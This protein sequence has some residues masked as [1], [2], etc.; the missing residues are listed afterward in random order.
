MTAGAEPGIRPYK[1]K[2]AGK[3]CSTSPTHHK[4]SENTPSLV[5][6]LC[7][8][9]SSV[10]RRRRVCGTK[11]LMMVGF[12]IQCYLVDLVNPGIRVI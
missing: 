9:F 3:H 7:K 11:G 1:S 4:L 10:L 5:N 2:I 6:H 8:V 12:Q